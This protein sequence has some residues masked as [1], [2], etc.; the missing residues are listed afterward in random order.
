MPSS[1][2]TAVIPSS[3]HSLNSHPLPPSLPH[4]CL[5]LMMRQCVLTKGTQQVGRVQCSCEGCGG[6]GGAVEHTH[7]GIGSDVVLSTHVRVAITAHQRQ[8]A[9]QGWEKG[10]ERGSTLQMDRYCSHTCTADSEYVPVCP[11]QE[12]KKKRTAYILK[13]TVNSQAVSLIMVGLG[14]V[15]LTRVYVF[16]SCHEVMQKHTTLHTPCMV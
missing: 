9:V 10:K 8:T 7:R 5:A 11:L 14:L 1:H 6:E 3:Q 4:H 12:R 13:N 16:Y 2:V 15:S